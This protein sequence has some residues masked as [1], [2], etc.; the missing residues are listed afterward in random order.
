M[1][2]TWAPRFPTWFKPAWGPQRFSFGGSVDNNPVPIVG[3]GW[4]DR[5]NG[6][7]LTP[8]SSAATIVFSTAYERS[9]WNLGVESLGPGTARLTVVPATAGIS[10]EQA[11]TM[12]GYVYDLTLPPTAHSPR[13]SVPCVA[14]R[15]ALPD[16]GSDRMLI[17]PFVTDFRHVQFDRFVRNDNLTSSP[18]QFVSSFVYHEVSATGSIVVAFQQPGIYFYG[19]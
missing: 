1:S 15:A 10:S 16:T 13:R 6:T 3:S 11:L 2:G 19:T 9:G 4:T 7:R 14:W 12:W 18:P 5:Y 17:G 8:N